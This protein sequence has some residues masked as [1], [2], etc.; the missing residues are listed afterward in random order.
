MFTFTNTII[1]NIL[2]N[3]QSNYYLQRLVTW[4]VPSKNLRRIWRHQIYTKYC[5]HTINSLVKK[6]Y[7]DAYVFFSRNGV[8]DVFFAASFIKEFKKTHPGRVIYVTEKKSIKNLLE[9]FKSIDEVVYD[10][11]LGGLQATPIVQRQICKGRLNFLFFPYRGSKPN[12]TFADSYANLLDV[13]LD[14][15][16]ELPTITKKDLH[17]AN[18]EFKDLKLLPQKTIVL[19]P[20]SV[21]WRYFVLTPNFWKRLAHKLKTMGFD[22]V[23]N[24]SNKAYKSF[25][26]TFLPLNA[27]LAF[28]SQV[29]HIYSFRSGINDLLVGMGI[30]H[31][32]AIY[33]NNM[34][35]TWTDKFSFDE[36]LNKYHV[37]TKETELDNLMQI[38][39]LSSIFNVKIDEIVYDELS[40]ERL[41]ETLLKQLK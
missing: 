37:K 13:P 6:K 4:F 8:G 33:P 26:T 9:A 31:L 1:D 21:M 30:T 35:V 36:L 24:S 16:R 38:Y 17:L 40:E 28:A 25:K 15:E 23:F 3:R 14:S 2:Y 19:I 10:P 27:F 7:S 12:Y 32:T 39:S 11:Y 20:E 18:K 34:E 41:L 5:R 29:K 22:V